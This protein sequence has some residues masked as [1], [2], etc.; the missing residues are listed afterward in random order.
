MEFGSVMKAIQPV[1][2]VED[3]RAQMIEN[4]RLRQ[5][6]FKRYAG[7]FTNCNKLVGSLKPGDIISTPSN[8]SDTTTTRWEHDPSQVWVAC[9]GSESASVQEGLFL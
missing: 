6:P 9:R 3:R 8:H 2:E 1:G 7:R 5:E 4:K